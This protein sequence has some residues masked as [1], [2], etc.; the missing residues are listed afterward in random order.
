MRYC[1]KCK[2]K[3]APKMKYCPNCFT[4]VPSW[5]D[6]VKTSSKVTQP[7]LSTR[8]GVGGEVKNTGNGG[9]KFQEKRSWVVAVGVIIVVLVAGA[10]SARFIFLKPKDNNAIIAGTTTGG[11]VQTIKQAAPAALGVNTTTK[12]QAIKQVAR[13]AL[14]TSAAAGNVQIAA[15]LPTTATTTNIPLKVVSVTPPAHAGDAVTFNILTLPDH[16]VGISIDATSAQWMSYETTTDSKGNGSI[17]LNA[18][19]AYRPLTTGVHQ[20]MVRLYSTNHGYVKA[21]EPLPHQ[22]PGFIVAQTDTSFVVP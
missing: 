10:V 14:A 21:N 13:S 17:T 7:P 20:A 8:F 19:Y 15:P 3:L 11:K 6:T 22:S 5:S 16:D 4:M 12:G 18:D 9:I 1:A 2:T